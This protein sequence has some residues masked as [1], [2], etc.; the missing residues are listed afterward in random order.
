MS[1]AILKKK[2]FRGGN[3]RANPISGADDSRNGLGFNINGVLR[4]GSSVRVTNL[5]PSANSNNRTSCLNSQTGC[6]NDSRY[7]KT[8]V[9]NTRGM[10]ASRR[11]CNSNSSDSKCKDPIN[12]V[13]PFSSGTNLQ[14]SQGQFIS[15][16]RESVFS[17]HN[18]TFGSIELTNRLANE[19]LRHRTGLSN[20]KLNRF[21]ENLSNDGNDNKCNCNFGSESNPP[22]GIRN[23][24]QRRRQTRSSNITSRFRTSALK[25]SDYQRSLY[26][27]RQCIPVPTILGNHENIR[28]KISWPGIVNNQSCAKVQ[29]S[30][31]DSNFLD[32]QSAVNILTGELNTELLSDLNINESSTNNLLFNRAL[33]PFLSSNSISRL[34]T[35]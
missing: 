20:N 1:I 27:A 28:K 14:N 16:K 3:S 13:Q 10:L 32:C 34:V 15:R 8:S 6:F 5:A 35:P 21:L 25:S 26:L 24:P 19:L 12:W 4:V 11:I 17:S 30:I 9:K 29:K 22:P 7:I 18:V 2:T 33:I 31:N 23:L